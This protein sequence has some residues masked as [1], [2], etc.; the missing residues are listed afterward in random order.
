MGI[1]G[2]P[3]I[4]RDSSLILELDAADR[5]SYQ[6]GSTTWFDLTNNQL[7]GSFVGSGIT[8]NSNTGGSLQFV[9]SSQHYVN[10]GNP[11]ILQIT[12]G[13]L[14]VFANATAFNTTYGTNAGYHGIVAK[15]GAWG[16]F[17]NN[18]VLV[19]FDWGTSVIRTTG[20]TIGN[21][22]WS[23]I[24]IAFTETTGT[25]S[26]NAIIYLNGSTVLTT[27]IKHSYQTVDLQVGYANSTDQYFSGNIANVRVYN[28]VLSAQEIQQNYNQL[29]SR[30]NL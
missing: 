10:I 17:V 23:H 28:R 14:E 15:Q 2:G 5:N 27:T 11:S 30:F 1:S 16:L 3:K 9:S 8:F 6:S 24:V 19:T 26:N 13:T 18:N 21:N 7:T 22:T 25:P 29:K 20:I 12:Q 4:V